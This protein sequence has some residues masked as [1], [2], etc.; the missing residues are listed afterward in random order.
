MNKPVRLRR[1][2]FSMTG[3]GWS[4]GI[5]SALS[6][7]GPCSLAGATTEP[8]PSS[9]STVV[10]SQL[11][12]PDYQANPAG[13][14]NGPITESNISEFGPDSGIIEQHIASGDITGYVRSWDQQPP[15]GNAVVILAITFSNPSGIPSFLAG[16]DQAANSHYVS[17]F[18]VPGIENAT[19]YKTTTTSQ[20][21]VAETVYVVD[22]AK[23]N[24]AFLV[25]GATQSGPLSQNN[26]TTVASEQWSAAPGSAV[27]SRTSPFS[28][29]E[30][31]LGEVLFYVVVAALVIWLISFLV[32]RRKHVVTRST[33]PWAAPSQNITAPSPSFAS[34]LEVGWHAAGPNPNEQAYWDS[35]AWTAT[36]RWTAGRGWSE[37]PLTSV[38]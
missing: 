12:L 9:L 23:G 10:L 4:L 14:T 6:L 33:T 24:S 29:T 30:Y 32:R 35:R 3:L 19:G 36:R 37:V 15:N 31:R 16:F 22:F 21:G 27:T 5:A 25:E 28:S 26:V 13:A 18:P 20:S 17:Q 1:M 34:P 7:L 8:P 2:G 38:P 11:P